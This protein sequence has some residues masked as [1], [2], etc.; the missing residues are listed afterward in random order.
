MNKSIFKKVTALSLAMIL[1][2]GV[3]A[4]CAKKD[5]DT[6]KSSNPSSPGNNA[7][8]DGEKPLEPMDVTLFLWGDK[9]NQMDDI[10]AEFKTR[11]KDELN[12]NFNI[13][14]APQ[15]DYPNNIKLKLS[16]GE[17]VDMCF[18][19]PWMNMNTFIMQG[20]YRDLTSYFHNDQYPGLKAAF[21]EE[22]MSNNLMGEN[23]DKVYGIPLTQTFGGASFVYLR[24]DL[25][26]KYGLDPIKTQEDFE[27][28]MAK[29][30][31]NEKTMIP[32]VMK[33]D[34][35]YGASGVINSEYQLKDLVAKSEA[36]MWDVELAPGVTATLY[37]K[38]YK[39][40]DCVLAGEPSSAKSVLP[41]P[42]NKTDLKNAKDVRTW[43]EKGFI[44]KDVITREDAQ[45][46][47]TSGKAA[48]FCWD[49]A[50]YNAT[51]SAL[52][53][54]IPEAKLEIFNYNPVYS[55]DLNG[56]N[57]GSYQA[58]NF[59]SIP[60]TTSDEKTE[61]IMKF[62]DWI[63]TSN[64]NHDLFEWGIDGKNFNAVGEDQYSYP[65]GLDL[66]KNYNFP[67][68]LLTW[69]PN[70]I[71]YPVGYPE[72]VLNTMKKAN[73]PETYYDPLVSG[74][75]FNGDPVKN[76]LANPDFLTAK[77]RRE[78]L[79]MGIFADV[80]AE[81]AKIDADMEK[82][83]TL[84]EDIAAIKAEVIKQAEGYLEKRKA[85]DEAS[86]KKYPT[87]AELESQLK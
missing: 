1:S 31:E 83:K 7:S 34:N 56:L 55:E 9:P 12:M 62:F 58:W 46:T 74:L 66:T 64:E 63:F 3:L 80:E 79:A 21:N 10:L 25:R 37:I 38:D 69:N 22:F 14:W 15:S 87:T 43:Y 36:G 44:E 26:E 71:R 78:N 60:V 2:A 67:G 33:K 41:E 54:S 29:V 76:E 75:R 82:N 53:A 5:D 17:N 65:E 32:F 68:F 24:G 57:K 86:G 47:F 19:A 59:I 39:I 11:T 73:D 52:E 77:T 4:S 6:N 61:R 16:A 81:N 49:I 23:G 8:T 70:F 48:S 72:E 40:V 45:G 84:Q 35:A 85:A 42:F 18:D 13:N 27:A 20:N 50:Q 30:V 51:L 28:Y